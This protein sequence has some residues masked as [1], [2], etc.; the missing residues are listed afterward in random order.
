MPSSDQKLAKDLGLRT[1]D[2]FHLTFRKRSGMLESTA[3]L[4]ADTIS[5]GYS[6][7]DGATVFLSLKTAKHISGADGPGEIN[8]FLKNPEQSINIAALLQQKLP[9]LRVQSW[10][11]AW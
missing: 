1:G 10:E 7:I 4:L 3:F 9:T 6:D 11:Q 2:S 5:S 8:L